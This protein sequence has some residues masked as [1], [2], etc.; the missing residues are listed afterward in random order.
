MRPATAS[1]TRARCT[2]ERPFLAAL[3]ID[4]DPVLVAC[5]LAKLVDTSCVISA[6]HLPQ[7]PA[8]GRLHSAGV[9][10]IVA[11]LRLLLLNLCFSRTHLSLPG[12]R[13]TLRIIGRNLN[14]ML[15]G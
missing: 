6:N 14:N 12:H 2:A 9:L 7:V 8:D 5:G 13:T 15:S 3:R 1:G 4:V 10:K 11:S